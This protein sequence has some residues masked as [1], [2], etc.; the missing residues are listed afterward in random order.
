MQLGKPYV[1]GD[2]GPSTF[3]CSGLVQFVYGRVGIDVPRTAAQ[4]QQWSTRVTAPRPGDLVF[5][6][7]PAYHVGLYLGAGKMIDAPKPGANVRVDAIGHPTSYGR[8]PGVDS[9]GSAVGGVLGGAG[10][11]VSG[12]IDSA[13]GKVR[14][15][16][17]EGAFVV[18]GLVLLAAGAYVAV[19]PTVHRATARLT[20]GVA[21]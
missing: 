3:D 12:W 9:V 18:L 15:I 6:G 1:Y 7:D 10:S 19:R 13:A 21:A 16:A 11:T 2:E 8:V 20:G 14:G 17:L 4:Q 5:Y